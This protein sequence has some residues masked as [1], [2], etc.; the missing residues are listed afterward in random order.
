MRSLLEDLKYGL[1]IHAKTAGLTTMA[2]LTLALGIG[3]CTAVFGVVNAILLRPLPY[4]ESEK[5]VI[6]WRLAPRGMELG[7]DQIPWGAN[8]FQLFL[9]ESRSMADLA[10]FKSQ[11]FTLTGI[12]DPK[13]LEGMKVS[14]GFFSALGVSPIMGRTFAQEEDQPGREHEVILSHELWRDH[15]GASEHLLGLPLELNGEAYTIVGVMPPGFAFPRANEMPGSFE[16]AR[17]AQLWVPLALPEATRA[18]D[19]A[20]LAVIGRLKPGVSMEDARSEFNVFGKR[21]DL[22]YPKLKGWFNSRVTALN[23]Q[24][25]GDTRLPL[26]L[27]LGA[28]G[29]VLLIACS[30]VA[31]LLLTRSLVRRREF[32]VRAALGA[33]HRRLV[34]Q[35]LTE[36]LL[37]G[38]AAGVLGVLL[39]AAGI[40]L[41]KIF[42]PAN[43]PRL[44]EASLDPLVFGFACAITIITGILFG[45]APAIGAV[46]KN[47][48]ESLKEGGQ[49]T[50]GTPAGPIVRKAL[51]ISQVALALILVIASGLVTKTFVRL[52]SVD[53]GFNAQH[54]L[55]FEVSLSGSR[56][57]ESDD[58]VNLYT[59]LLR[60]LR[61]VSGVQSVGVTQVVPMGGSPDNT[62]IRIPDRPALATNE[63]PMASYTIA[64]PGYF[65][66]VGTPLLRGRD[67]LESDN[68]DSMP[69]TIINNAMARKFWPGKNPIGKEVRLGSAK[70][71]PMTII[72][73]VADV[74][75]MSFRED[76]GPEM[77]VPY[78][79]KPWPSMLRMQVA[80]RTLDDPTS[81]TGSV[82]TA[83]HSID[84]ELPMAKVAT[85]TTL[86][87]NSMAEPRFA[88]LLLGAFGILA[89]VLASIGMYSVIS[90]SVTQRTQEIGIR[91]ALGAQRR[92]V[93]RMILSQ[94]AR[95]AG[96]GVVIG[97]LFSLWITQLM[98]GL[99]YGVRPID[100]FVYSAAVSVLLLSVALLACYVPARRATQV[101]P[102]I[103]LRDE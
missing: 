29:A 57:K 25:V 51:I 46:R 99:L 95:L 103:T 19:A 35:V 86:A 45:M 81:V 67:F 32:T 47:L 3:A 66:A 11:S 69:V 49:R 33:G 100:P 10:A 12:D 41:V 42:G 70:Y 9:R 1:R 84:S 73:V 91:M 96:V 98:H 71:P 52:L 55:T 21:E 20:E 59:K 101:D 16:F 38:V 2:V 28:V 43:I 62:A 8:Q 7:F 77:Y 22:E 93:F 83:I 60:Q 30:N 61:W 63:N 27:M 31:S 58:I 40:Y 89:L 75:H 78:T 68:S 53:S 23:A 76:S 92:D 36:S 97:L 80:V 94:G 54:V 39:G 64:S 34:R 88:M 102:M 79:Q 26:M 44:Q 74:K 24:V 15:F 65:A 82:R 17:E 56:Y 72:G 14:A 6:P 90:Y 85:L 37:L 48:A 13:L 50:G 5:I 87:D 4:S 18:D